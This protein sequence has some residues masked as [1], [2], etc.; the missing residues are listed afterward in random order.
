MFGQDRRIRFREFLALA[1]PLMVRDDEGPCVLLA[2]A[3]TSDGRLLGMVVGPGGGEVTFPGLET[4]SFPP[5]LQLRDVQHV[6]TTLGAVNRA[7]RRHP[8]ADA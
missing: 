1:A 5:P 8:G 7:Q 4:L 6:E 2:F 3:I